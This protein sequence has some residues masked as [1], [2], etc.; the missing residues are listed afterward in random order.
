[1]TDGK[2]RHALTHGNVRQLI[3][4]AVS[5]NGIKVWSSCVHPAQDKV[6]TNMAAVPMHHTQ[7]EIAITQHLFTNVVAQQIYVPIILE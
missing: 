1:M 2:I 7:P 5:M 3:S 4:A 6:S